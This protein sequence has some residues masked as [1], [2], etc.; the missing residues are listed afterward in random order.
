MMKQLNVEQLENIYS[1]AEIK[2]VSFLIDRVKRNG[3]EQVP[4]TKYNSLPAVEFAIA[5]N[6]DAVFLKYYVTEKGIRAL[7]LFA[8]SPFFILKGAPFLSI[9]YK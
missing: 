1:I 2:V 6:T 3:L 7:G 5:Y 4:W 9:T 8:T